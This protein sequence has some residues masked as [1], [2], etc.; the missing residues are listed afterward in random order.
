MM[1]IYDYAKPGPK[2]GFKS[3]LGP[4]CTSHADPHL[5]HTQSF[6]SNAF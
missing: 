3:A 4:E 6:C 1:V 5:R 2:M